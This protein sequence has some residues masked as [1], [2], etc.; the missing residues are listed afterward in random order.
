MSQNILAGGPQCR[1]LA[2]E[3]STITGVLGPTPFTG[4]GYIDRSISFTVDIMHI[5]GNICRDALNMLMGTPKFVDTLAASLNEFDMHPDIADDIT[6]QP[7]SWSKTVQHHVHTKMLATKF[8]TAWLED[9]TNIGDLSE[10]GTLI[11]MKT[12]SYHVL[13]ESGLLA[14]LGNWPRGTKV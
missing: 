10:K 13:L 8:P 7:Y 12:H 6:N 4:L 3:K 5:S 14:E 1:P 9:H 11:G 2:A